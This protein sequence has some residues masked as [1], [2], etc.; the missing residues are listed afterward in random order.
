MWSMYVSL[1]MI[2]RDSYES[3]P[4]CP[5]ADAKS[6]D[7]TDVEEYLT[8][9]SKEHYKTKTFFSSRSGYCVFLMLFTTYPKKGTNT[10]YLDIW[11][12]CFSFIISNSSNTFA[13]LGREQKRADI[14]VRGYKPL[15]DFRSFVCL[16]VIT[17]FR[18]IEPLFPP[19][20]H[21]CLHYDKNYGTD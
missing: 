17:D 6:E 15:S 18:P 16:L 14:L 19:V 9:C 10:K 4:Y 3:E 1:L 13:R 8:D 20:Y 21:L 12:S 2:S 5:S 11:M 7:G